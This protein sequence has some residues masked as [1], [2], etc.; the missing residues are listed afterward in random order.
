MENKG[1]PYHDESGKFTSKGREGMGGTTK[2]SEKSSD[3]LMDLYR[4]LMETA[5]SLYPNKSKKEEK[6]VVEAPEENIS[7]DS[8]IKVELPGGGSDLVEIEDL[9]DK[10]VEFLSKDLNLTEEEKEDIRMN[11]MVP[12]SLNPS[13]SPKE[14]RSDFVEWLKDNYYSDVDYSEEDEEYERWKERDE[15]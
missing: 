6:P 13:R 8:E 12:A 15:D 3:P 5:N 1:N 9:G 10:L 14:L 7:F 4:S 2:S 11:E